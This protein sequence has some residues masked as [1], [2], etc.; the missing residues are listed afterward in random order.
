MRCQQSLER[1]QTRQATQVV[2]QECADGG[3]FLATVAGEGSVV[4]PVLSFAGGD[5]RHFHS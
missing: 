5:A 2:T 3:A 4:S 1:L